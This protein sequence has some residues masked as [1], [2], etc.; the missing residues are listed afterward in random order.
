MAEPTP[1]APAAPIR[2]MRLRKVPASRG[3]TWVRMGLTLVARQP[4]GFIGLFGMTLFGTLLLAS[5]PV[6]GAL[7]VGVLQPSIWLGFMRASQRALAGERFGPQ[8]LAEAW[9]GRST[10]QRLLQLRLGV[11]YLLAATGALLVAGLLGSG[12]EAWQAVM[13]AT[14][15]T[16][17]VALD[18]PAL[19]RDLL[20]ALLCYTPVSLAFWHAPA[21][22]HW[23]GHKPGQ[24]IFSSLV[25]CW[26][27]KGA[28]FV[29]GLGWAALAALLASLLGVLALLLGAQPALLQVLVFPLVLALGGAFYASLYFTVVDCFE[30]GGTGRATV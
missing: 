8:V 25:A 10:P 21:L 20:L 29:Y 6:L 7:A 15:E 16:R 11:A 2:T 1:L 19:Q 4:L 9:L 28:F 22:V 13:E 3:L 24:A 30:Q 18:A 23:A 5:L 27:N 17:D 12:G 14:P 26:H